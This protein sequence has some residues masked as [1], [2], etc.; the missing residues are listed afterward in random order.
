M[1][2]SSAW[3]TRGRL[4]RAVST[5][6]DLGERS[7]TDPRA[8]FRFARPEVQVESFWGAE[9]GVASLASP[10]ARPGPVCGGGSSEIPGAD[11]WLGQGAER[12]QFQPPA[13]ATPAA[14]PTRGH[15]QVR[16]RQPA[17]MPSSHRATWASVRAVWCHIGLLRSPMP[18]GKTTVPL[19][20]VGMGFRHGEHL[21]A[22]GSRHPGLL[23]WRPAFSWTAHAW[24]RCSTMACGVEADRT[25][26]GRT[27]RIRQCLRRVGAGR[28]PSER[29]TERVDLREDAWRVVSP[30]DVSKAERQRRLGKDAHGTR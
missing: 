27:Y 6:S 13:L 5:T 12:R 16:P 15:G 28:P 10:R 14:A 23:E 3:A 8:R 7:L 30:A 26:H 21:I 11:H 1:D 22:Q 24:C 4:A 2:E 20:W 25:I 9:G 29:W 19:G 18:L 17:Q